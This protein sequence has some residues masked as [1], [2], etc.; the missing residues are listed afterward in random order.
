MDRWRWLQHERAERPPNH[1]LP[2]AASSGRDESAQ[3]VSSFLANENNGKDQCWS[4]T[5]HLN[6]FGL[7]AAAAGSDRAYNR[8][9]GKTDYSCAFENPALG[10]GLGS[11]A[12]QGEQFRSNARSRL[13]AP[14]RP[15]TVRSRVDIGGLWPCADRVCYARPNASFGVP[16]SSRRTAHRHLPAVA[17][18]GILGAVAVRRATLGPGDAAV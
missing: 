14:M 6:R 3:R 7:A 13:I 8:V 4:A 5:V 15:H 12:G 17:P 18:L 9:R 16:S 1:R 10:V 2:N 11:D